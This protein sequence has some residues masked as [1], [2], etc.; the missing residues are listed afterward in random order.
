MNNLIAHDEI[1]A[2]LLEAWRGAQNGQKELFAAAGKAL[3][4]QIEQTKEAAKRASDL[5]SEVERLRQVNRNLQ[6]AVEETPLPEAGASVNIKVADPR[7]RI[8]AQFT[9]RGHDPD[10]LIDQY[11]AYAQRLFDRGL[12]SEDEYIDQRRGERS[13]APVSQPAA[14]HLPPVAGSATVP[15][16]GGELSFEAASLEG[17]RKKGKDYWKVKGG[18]FQRHGVTIWPEVLQ[19]AGFQAEAMTTDE[20]YSLAGYTAFYAMNEEGTNPQKVTRLVKN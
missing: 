2:Q 8:V 10:T 13:P 14:A 12:V 15:P 17:E 4:G 18:K 16:V 19:A 7:T 1:L 6:K 5:E 20:V 3:K 11:F 9:F